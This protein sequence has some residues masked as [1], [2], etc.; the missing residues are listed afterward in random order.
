MHLK[1]HPMLCQLH[2]P[3]SFHIILLIRYMRE[4]GMCIRW[5]FLTKIKKNK[6]RTQLNINE[7][8]EKEIDFQIQ[9]TLSNMYGRLR[10]FCG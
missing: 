3:T 10:L 2:W 1:C 4:L 6:K 5:P 9:L 8:F 7:S